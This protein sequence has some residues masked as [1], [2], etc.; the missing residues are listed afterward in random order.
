M[1]N[2][3]S[4]ASL[5]L[6]AACGPAGDTPW[7]EN[8]DGLVTACEGLNPAACTATPGC[9][10]APVLCT[11]E[12]RDDG[13]GGCLPCPTAG[14]CQPVALD[15]S[16]QAPD[17]CGALPGCELVTQTVCSGSAGSG[18]AGSPAPA[19]EDIGVVA[20]PPCGGTCHVVEV[21]QPRRPVACEQLPHEA[22]LAQPGCALEVGV[23]TFTCDPRGPC[24]PCANPVE[25]CVTV[26]PPP[27]DDC[28]PR[29]V[30]SCAVDGRCQLVDGP[31]CEVAC[32]AG[33]PCPP[34]ATPSPV[35]VPVV[36]VPPTEDCSTRDPGTCSADGRCVLSAGVCPAVCQPDGAGGC[37]PCDPGARC[38]PVVP[39]SRCGGLERAAC[40]AAGCQVVELDI[41][42]FA[43]PCD[44]F[45]CV[46]PAVD[47]GSA[48]PRP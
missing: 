3:L 46:E 27:L 8:R 10:Q 33:Q 15:C 25:R 24:P 42:C 13:H 21:C 17:A 43:E 23:C 12:C 4:I 36:E 39:P 26:R 6:L 5:T 34:C 44:T 11:M 31:V 2:L 41:A 1:R 38:V 18:T 35:C 48:P 22:C 28:G 14:A 32:L 30:S 37:M 45:R 29:D 16:A 9:A 19:Q 7:D 20:P 47:G 40:S